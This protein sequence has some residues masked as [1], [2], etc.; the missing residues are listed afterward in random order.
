MHHYTKFCCKRIS[1]SED[2]R[3]KPRH[4]DK[5]TNWQGDSRYPY[6]FISEEVG[7]TITENPFRKERKNVSTSKHQCWL[8]TPNC[9]DAWWLAVQRQH[10][11]HTHAE[12]EHLTTS[13]NDDVIPS[14]DNL[15]DCG[16]CQE[17]AVT[18]VEGGGRALGEGYPEPGE[19]CPVG[20]HQPW[21]MLPVTIQGT[22]TTT[23][24]SGTWSCFHAALLMDTS[25][26]YQ[27]AM[28]K[29]WNHAVIYIYKSIHALLGVEH[30]S[31][32]TIL[33]WM[34]LHKILILSELRSCCY[35]SSSNRHTT[36]WLTAKFGH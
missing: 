29:K 31:T 1:S 26:N 9:K 33:H 15:P 11:K 20:V 8:L 5:Q 21:V 32:S 30:H 28:L 7:D 25:S 16:L 34:T 18:S 17:G 27:L 19:G 6:S 14:G 12:G 36:K 23:A 24:W 4:T 13:A 10:Q 35:V 3:T 2:L 22:N